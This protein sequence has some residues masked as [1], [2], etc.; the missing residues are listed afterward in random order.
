MLN[1]SYIGIQSMYQTK[2]SIISQYTHL[3]NKKNKTEISQSLISIFMEMKLK[4]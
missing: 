4:F 1:N 2:Q 3:Q